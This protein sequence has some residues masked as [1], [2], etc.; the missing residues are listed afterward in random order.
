[1]H[2][3]VLEAPIS[4]LLG[5]DKADVQPVVPLEVGFQATPV[6]GQELAE[7][8]DSPGVKPWAYS[9]YFST[10]AMAPVNEMRG[11]SSH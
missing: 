6:L 2:R 8:S 9:E 10:S 11:K 3:E 5:T 4:Q 7:A 1:M